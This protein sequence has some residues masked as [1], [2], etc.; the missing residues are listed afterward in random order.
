MGKARFIKHE[1]IRV[2]DL[3]KVTGSHHDMTITRQGTVTKRLHYGRATEYL[4]ADNVVLLHAYGDGGSD[5]NRF[6]VTLLSRPLDS[7]PFSVTDP[8]PTLF[9][10][11]TDV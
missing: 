3:I 6:T 8:E 2:K 7:A 10:D 9:E 11:L 4:T 5:L 1:S